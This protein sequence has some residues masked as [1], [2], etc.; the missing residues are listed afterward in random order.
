MII[1]KKII[2][3]LYNNKT[4]GDL[5]IFF[6]KKSAPYMPSNTVINCIS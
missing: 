1:I 5:K 3:Q 6:V 2:P 4:Q